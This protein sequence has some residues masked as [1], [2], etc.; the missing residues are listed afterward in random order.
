MITNKL[1]KEAKKSDILVEFSDK[2]DLPD[3]IND[4]MGICR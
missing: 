3:A 4:F 2:K 1:N